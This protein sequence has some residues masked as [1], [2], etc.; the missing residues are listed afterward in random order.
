MK[1]VIEVSVNEDNVLSVDV[2]DLSEYKYFNEMMM[3]GG[4]FEEIGIVDVDEEV[5]EFI[6]IVESDES[7]IDLSGLNEKVVDIVKKIVGEKDCMIWVKKWGI[8]S[9]INM[10]I[11][12]S[13]FVE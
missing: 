1:K 4:L 8:D 6:E 3:E 9:D 7:E 10:S 2:C 13:E 12:I 5:N 11:V